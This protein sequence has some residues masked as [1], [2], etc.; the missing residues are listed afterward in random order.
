MHVILF[1]QQAPPQHLEPPQHQPHQ[2]TQAHQTAAS[3]VVAAALLT[4][5]LPLTKQQMETD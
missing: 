1:L 5:K 3:E 2:H 4:D